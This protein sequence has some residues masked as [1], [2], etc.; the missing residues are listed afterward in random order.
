MKNKLFYLIGVTLFF[1]FISTFTSCSDDGDEPIIDLPTT[2]TDEPEE[3]LK[4]D[5]SYSETN[6]KYVLK[7]TYN[8]EAI[9][10]KLVNFTADEKLENATVVLEGVEKDLGAMLSNLLELKVQT[11]SPIPGEKKVTLENVK[12]TPNKEGT[13]YSFEGSNTTPARIIAYKGTVKEGELSIDITNVLARQELAGTWEIADIPLS[14]GVPNNVD[15]SNLLYPLWVDWDSSMSIDAGVI[16]DFPLKA[17]VGVLLPMVAFV[18]P[19]LGIDFEGA[20]KKMLYNI[21]AQK[22][23]CMY[24][25]YSY[26]GDI[27]NPLWSEEMSRN[28]IRYYYGDEP[29]QIFIEANVD[30]IMNALSGL[31]SGG[32]TRGDEDPTLDVL[33]QQLGEVLKP[34]LENG[35]LC[36]YKLEGEKMSINIDGKFT[37]NLLKTIVAILNDP[38]INELIMN[39]INNDESLKVYAPNIASLIRTLPAALTYK[40]NPF[41]PNDQSSWDKPI[42]RC[43]YVK[44]GLQLVKSA[45]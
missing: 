43:E 8:G 45:D 40:G 31:I 28:I 18:G 44:I 5:G 7:M 39:M 41:D 13:A 37:L 15:N 1:C 2:P 26:S 22:N 17:P 14:S 23:G 32:K 16:M 3:K 9:N 4:L 20:I 11:N 29:N 12:L 24:A 36:N 38:T 27:N 19:S 33:L 10:G 35:F 21:T 25:K 34:A 42:G 30:F 6:E